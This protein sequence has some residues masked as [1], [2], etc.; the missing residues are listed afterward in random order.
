QPK[1]RLARFSRSLFQLRL[2]TEEPIVSIQVLRWFA[3]GAFHLR[4]IKPGSDCANHTRRYP[5]LKLEHVLQSAIEA[6]CP[7]VRAARRFNELS[8]YAHP[9]AN[10]AHAAL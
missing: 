5:I 3:L 4:P 6:I 2:A 9:T 10:L 7:Q 8:G 1:R